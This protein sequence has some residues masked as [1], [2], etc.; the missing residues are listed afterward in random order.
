[1]RFDAILALEQRDMLASVKGVP[2]Q[3]ILDKGADRAC[4]PRGCVE[5]D[6]AESDLTE[7]KVYE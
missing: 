7:E 3:P 5:E 4:C 1:M 6:A 2:R